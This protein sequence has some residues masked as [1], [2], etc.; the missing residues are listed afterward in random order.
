MRQHTT[1]HS[2]HATA[3]RYAPAPPAAPQYSTNYKAPQPVEV[4]HLSDAANATIPPDLREQFERDEYG[5]VLFFTVPPV[6]TSRDPG[7]PRIAHSAR[8]LAAKLKREE[9]TAAKRKADGQ[10]QQHAQEAAIGRRGRLR[11][12][13][14]QLAGVVLDGARQLLSDWQTSMAASTKADFQALYGAEWQR[15][16][17]EELDRVAVA[18]RENVRRVEMVA[19]Q[20]LHRSRTRQST[21]S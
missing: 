18:Q 7:A 13:R 5:R 8:Y 2:T 19:A 17:R 15:C 14:H 11:D 20:E 12:E 9:V 3:P 6:D 1:S 10:P 16:M 4:W 21:T